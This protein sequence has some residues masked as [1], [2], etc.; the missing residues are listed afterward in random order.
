MLQ[1]QDGPIDW[2][3]VGV[4]H[5]EGLVRHLMDLQSRESELYVR[6]FQLAVLSS[7]TF[8]VP[9]PWTGAPLQADR[10]VVLWDKS[11]FYG[12]G[13]ATDV[14]LLATSL[15]EGFPIAG[16]YLPSR[17]LFVNLGHPVWGARSEQVDALLALVGR[18]D[19]DR[20]WRERDASALRVVALTGDASFAHGI[21]NQLSAL[22]HLARQPA[23]A[24]A[25][26][27]VIV[28]REPILPL[29]E[30]FSDRPSWQFSHRFEH[31]LE[32]ANDPQTLFVPVGGKR[33]TRS[34]QARL[35]GAL[36][37]R[38]E[39]APFM[40]RPARPRFWLSIRTRNR[41]VQN[42]VEFL[43]AVVRMLV[44][45]YPDSEVVL[46][47]HSLPADNDAI[48]ALG[49]V[50]NIEFAQADRE[51]AV[52][53]YDALDARS[54]QCITIAVG[55]ETA[56]SLALA[57]HCDFYVCHHGT[58]Q[59]KVGWFAPVPGVA[60]S[61]AEIARANP[62][63]SVAGHVEGGVM[64]VYLPP[65]VLRDVRS[66]DLP[67]TALQNELRH[68]NY[69]VDVTAACAVIVDCLQKAVP[70]KVLMRGR[71]RKPVRNFVQNLLGRIPRLRP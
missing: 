28:T 36:G 63:P 3:E 17:D 44:A 23:I 41:T 56:A 65:E 47:G 55:L 9:S 57:R 42:Q 68:D 34:A 35:F 15:G 19:L 52:A 45:R 53:V 11:V 32:E 59:H 30:L 6:W 31:D 48:V 58:V 4:P 27:E 46:D 14:W 40:A 21:W 24:E 16:L 51:V 66:D 7:G 33:V 2:L 12:F 69:V 18:H 22:D 39:L 5:L 60:H 10:S 1:V 25:D 54:R 50:S 61:N 67:R 62:A 26:L 49:D 43:V 64:P 29:A 71:R 70:S 8:E 38:K 13:N 20:R 37:R